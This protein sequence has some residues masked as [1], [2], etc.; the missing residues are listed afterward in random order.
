MGI[1][2]KRR[3]NAPCVKDA[4][5]IV[6][7]TVMNKRDVSQCKNELQRYLS[8]LI[9]GNVPMK[10]LTITK[11]L[12]A[13]YK[14]PDGIAHAVLAERIGK[15]DPGNKPQPNDRI[16]YV[17]FRNPNGEIPKKQ[18]DRVET[19]EF[20]KEADL[21]PDYE[22]YIRNQIQRPVSQFLDLI[23]ENIPGTGITRE[24]WEERRVS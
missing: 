8:A 22:F 23:L 19:P 11:R 5:Q 4:Y 3:D 20:M 18:G 10:K 24:G 15:R 13:H 21:R 9:M 7:D 6:V 1:V 12:A 2:L 16:R 17:Y 14:N